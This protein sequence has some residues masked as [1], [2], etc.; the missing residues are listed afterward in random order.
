MNIKNHQIQDPHFPQFYYVF[1]GYF[2]YEIN[3]NEHIL[4]V[5]SVSHET[6]SNLDISTRVHL[7]LKLE[8]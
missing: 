2:R 7:H 8:I 3:E 4:S 6:R 1:M 5:R